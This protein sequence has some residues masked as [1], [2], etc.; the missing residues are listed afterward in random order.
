MFK[1]KRRHIQRKHRGSTH[2]QAKLSFH[3]QDS[4]P[5][6]NPRRLPNSPP[7]NLPTHSLPR[8][9]T[10]LRKSPNPLNSY[11]HSSFSSKGNKN[12]FYQK[13][14]RKNKHSG[15]KDLVNLTNA[16]QLLGG[17]LPI[18]KPRGVTS[19][20]LSNYIRLKLTKIH[21]ALRFGFAGTLDENAQG[22]FLGAVGTATP[23][24][25][26]ILPH[27]KT[28]VARLKLGVETDSCDVLG[29]EIG[30][31]ELPGDE[32]TKDKIEEIIKEHFTGEIQQIPPAFSSLK[33]D[34]VRASTLAR[35][36]KTVQMA[37]RKVNIHSCKVLGYDKGYLDLEV[38]CGKGTYIRSLALDIAKAIGTTCH[39]TQLTRTQVGLAKMNLEVGEEGDM[40]DKYDENNGPNDE[41]NAKNISRKKSLQYIPPLVD[42]YTELIQRHNVYSGTD[43]VA[44]SILDNQRNYGV[45]LS[46][47]DSQFTTDHI[48]VADSI[49]KR[50]NT[51]RA[52]KNGGFDPDKKYRPVTLE[53][54]ISDESGGIILDNLLPPHFAVNYSQYYDIWDDEFNPSITHGQEGNHKVVKVTQNGKNDGDNG[55]GGETDKNG[56]ASDDD[57]DGDSDDGNMEGSDAEGEIYENKPIFSGNAS[58]KTLTSTTKAKQIKGLDPS[59]NITTNIF[60]EKIDYLTFKYSSPEANASSHNPNTLLSSEKNNDNVIYGIDAQYDPD[61]FTFFQK[62]KLQSAHKHTNF[63][64]FHSPMKFL[65]D[66][67]NSSRFSSIY[68]TANEYFYDMHMTWFNALRPDIFSTQALKEMRF[69]LKKMRLS[70]DL[71]TNYLSFEKYKSFSKYKKQTSLDPEN[72]ENSFHEIDL[73]ELNEHSRNT[74]NRVS[75]SL[76]LYLPNLKYEDD[77]PIM[78]VGGS[79]PFPMTK[80]SKKPYSF[81]VPIK[82]SPGNNQHISS[83]VDD[84]LR[85]LATGTVDAVNDIILSSGGEDG[86]KNGTKSKQKDEQNLHQITSASI[87]LNKTTP[88]APD[89]IPPFSIIPTT[90]N[91][92]QNNSFTPTNPSKNGQTN[93]QTNDQRIDPNDNPSDPPTH[94]SEYNLLTQT[95]HRFLPAVYPMTTNQLIAHQRYYSR[96]ENLYNERAVLS[97][98]GEYLELWDSVNRSRA[99]VLDIKKMMLQQYQRRVPLLYYDSRVLYLNR[100]GNDHRIKSSPVHDTVAESVKRWRPWSRLTRDIQGNLLDFDGNGKLINMYDLSGNPERDE[101][102]QTH[103]KRDTAPFRGNA[104]RFK[105]GVKRSGESFEGDFEGDSFLYNP[106]PKLNSKYNREEYVNDE[107]SN[108]IDEYKYISLGPIQYQKERKKKL[109]FFKQ[110]GLTPNINNVDNNNNNNFDKNFGLSFEEVSTQTNEVFFQHLTNHAKNSPPHQLSHN[111]NTPVNFSPITLNSNS[112]NGNQSSQN[113]ENRDQ[114]KDHNFGQ[115]SDG[116]AILQNNNSRRI[117]TFHEKRMFIKRL[118]IEHSKLLRRLSL[119][120]TMLE[121]LTQHYLSQR[122]HI[123]HQRQL[124]V[125]GVK[126]LQNTYTK[127]NK[128][129]KK[130]A[131]IQTIIHENSRLK[132]QIRSREEQLLLLTDRLQT[133]K[134]NIGRSEI[135]GGQDG[136]FGGN[137]DDFLNFE[138]NFEHAEIS[139][140]DLNFDS[141]DPQNQNTDGHEDFSTLDIGSSNEPYHYSHTEPHNANSFDEMYASVQKPQQPKLFL[142]DT[143]G[144]HGNMLGN[145]AEDPFGSFGGHL[146]LSDLN[147]SSEQLSDDDFRLINKNMNTTI[148]TDSYDPFG[149]NGINRDAFNENNGE[150][151]EVGKNNTNGARISAF[152]LGGDG[153]TSDDFISTTFPSSAA[154]RQ[155]KRVDSFSPKR[156]P[157]HSQSSNFNPNLSKV[158]PSHNSFYSHSAGPYQS[159]SFTFDESSGEDEPRKSGKQGFKM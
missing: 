11:Q 75:Q 134:S 9:N 20:D 55:N 50:F 93:G 67:N 71:K 99:N 82:V 61:E 13:H 41:N 102:S 130:T 122:Q 59:G 49:N 156:G 135:G 114:S 152:S 81:F 33:I 121:Q 142:L 21:P 149:V 65:M 56:P 24:L 132:E 97:A 88:L 62:M 111:L 118:K 128:K 30:T 139:N 125:S 70:H 86:T 6:Q 52:K 1:L 137:F 25:R 155:M 3:S 45:Y 90:L 16:P 26:Y 79:F 18:Y 157:N 101:K 115:N 57:R 78:L 68:S 22:I 150:K 98:P 2:T 39:L 63:V 89:D 8:I 127:L 69:L 12:K 146:A 91:Q 73:E 72:P 120:T 42:N 80:E 133:N 144:L 108:Y 74:Y 113:I 153:T 44:N 19:T 140:L 84:I 129:V 32:I 106:N 123:Y 151:Q 112:P 83:T 54:I 15:Q 77:H 147:L 36:G 103:K 51:L 85:V 58:S 145:S 53:E 141:I 117:M 159:K 136:E 126:D 109:N 66:Y 28:Y 48:A 47:S 158:G 107:V 96:I 5:L 60:G 34:G 119:E 87:L 35:E 148:N 95:P 94:L 110:M 100:Y 10:P 29:N 43:F 116:D 37:S 64:E 40:G 23:F 7:L 31:M 38:H 138:N 92:S 104:K 76:S 124:L 105:S 4:P 46:I 131:E 143:D 14:S 17:L 27:D 154:S